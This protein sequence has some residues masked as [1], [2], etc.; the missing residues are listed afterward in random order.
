MPQ[1]IQHIDAIA[2]QKGRAALSVS[3]YP[4]PYNPFD[5]FDYEKSKARKKVIKWLDKNSMPWQPCGEFAN[6]NRMM[7]Y[8]GDI[9]VDVPYDTEDETYKKLASFLENPDG[10]M[11]IEGVNFYYTPLEIA[12]KNKHHDEPGFWEKWAENF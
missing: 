9:Y 12:M 5:D 3:F 10:S 11:K 8:L 7:P 6:E 1:I 2:R 4:R